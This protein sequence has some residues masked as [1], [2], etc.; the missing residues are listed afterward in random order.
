YIR[1][2]GRRPA[3]SRAPFFMR[4]TLEIPAHG[5]KSMTGALR[6]GERMAD[7]KQEFLARMNAELDAIDAQL[8]EFRAKYR[9]EAAADGTDEHLL[10]TL[11]ERRDAIRRRSRELEDL[12]GDD[13]DV[14]R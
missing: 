7:R 1:V 8:D 9:G 4:R 14:A 10:G 11:A 3:K 12:D 13:W 6:R 5:P 2:N